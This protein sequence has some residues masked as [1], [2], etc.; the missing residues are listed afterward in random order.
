MSDAGP[1]R[2][3]VRP[4]LWPFANDRRIDVGNGAAPILYFGGCGGEENPGGR[5][6]PLRIA[7]REIGCRYRRPPKRRVERRD[8][9][10]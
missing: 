1:D 2:I 9:M 3:A 5:A 7:W 6:A 4:K 10:T 8:R